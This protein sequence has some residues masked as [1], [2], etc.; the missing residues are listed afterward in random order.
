MPS[1]FMDLTYLAHL[2]PLP[3]SSYAH[4]SY[5]SLTLPKW[6]PFHLYAFLFCFV[7]LKL[8][9]EHGGKHKL[10]ISPSLGYVIQQ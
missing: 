9:S 5:P 10:F 2:L 6:L 1:S 4:P 7:F 3:N 8:D